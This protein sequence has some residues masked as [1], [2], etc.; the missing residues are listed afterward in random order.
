MTINELKIA[1]QFGQTYVRRIYDVLLSY[2]VF[3]DFIYKICNDANLSLDEYV[4]RFNQWIE[5]CA[6]NVIRI[7]KERNEGLRL[8]ETND[9]AAGFEYLKQ[10]C[11]RALAVYFILKYKGDHEFKTC[12]WKVE[13]WYKFTTLS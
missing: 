8:L 5:S 3:K 13:S 2:I 4:H 12:S 10:S 6:N 1:A 11:I 9:V 7:C